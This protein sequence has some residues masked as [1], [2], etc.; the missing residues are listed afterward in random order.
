MYYTGNAVD[1]LLRQQEVGGQAH[2]YVDILMTSEWMDKYWSTA[3]QCEASTPVSAE[4][5][6]PVVRELFLK[7]RPRYHVCASANQYHYRKAEQGPYNFVCTSVALAMPAVEQPVVQNG[8]QQ[9]WYKLISINPGEG[10]QTGRA[11]VVKAAP[12]M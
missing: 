4:H 12:K 11:A 8:S 1:E 3:T 9:K 5:S 7:L 10:L 2:Q 6:S